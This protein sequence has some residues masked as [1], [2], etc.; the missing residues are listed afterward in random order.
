MEMGIEFASKM[1]DR[2]SD[3]D[4]T[5][6]FKHDRMFLDIVLTSQCY[7]DLHTKMS[8]VPRY[9]RHYLGKSF[10]LQ[11]QK[12][13]ASLYVRRL[14]RS[15]RCTIL[16]EARSVTEGL[17]VFDLSQ[18][19]NGLTGSKERD[20]FQTVQL[21]SEEEYIAKVSQKKPLSVLRF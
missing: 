5:Y 21:I 7:P 15:R 10:T 11:N 17:A 1:V 18:Y 13:K 12:G 20:A 19:G 4:A 8:V 3:T 6:S 2:H 14:G 9:I 16:V